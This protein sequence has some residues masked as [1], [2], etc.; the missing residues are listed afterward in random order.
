MSIP[1]SI[2][3]VAACVARSADA[4]AFYRDWGTLRTDDA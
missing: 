1:I 4:Q 3:A 2:G